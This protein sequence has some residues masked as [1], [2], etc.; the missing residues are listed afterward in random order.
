[1][2]NR[3][4]IVESGVEAAQTLARFFEEREDEVWHA[5]KLDE[6]ASLLDLVQ[7]NLM[8][9]DI[10]FPGDA[11][12]DFLGQT[13]HK[14]PNLNIIIT[15]KQID[16][17]RE[18]L[19]RQRGVNVFVRQPFTQR[20]LDQ[21][22]K[23]LDKEKS[24]GQF[25]M[26]RTRTLPPVRL[27]MR[28]KIILPFLILTF[29]FATLAFFINMQI[30]RDVRQ[31]YEDDRMTLLGTQGGNWQ[32]ENEVQMLTTLREA[33]STQGMS[34]ALVQ[35]DA[36]KMAAILEPVA[37][38]NH[39]DAIEVL[40][41]NGG[42]IFSVRRSGEAYVSKSGN[43][44]YFS[45]Q[46]AI[47]M[48]LKGIA[49][50][51]GDKYSLISEAPW[52]NMFYLCGPIYDDTGQPLGVILVGRSIDSI[53]MN[54]HHDLSLDVTLYDLNGH[55]LFTTLPHNLI[56]D[57]SA[58]QI[59]QILSNQN[60]L[61]FIRQL[62]LGQE[63]ADEILIPW[64]VRGSENI[65][66][67]GLTLNASPLYKV[68]PWLWVETSVLVILAMLTVWLVGN[69]L[70]RLFNKS[71]LRLMNATEEVNR[72]NLVTKVNVN[73]NDELSVLTHAFNSMLL[74]F[75]QNMLYRDLMG[76]APTDTNRK[77]MEQTFEGEGFNLRGQ[78]LDV[79]IL[80]SDV[81]DFTSLADKMDPEKAIEL[82]ND[83]FERLAAIVVSYNGVINKLEGDAMIVIFGALPVNLPPD[84]SAQAACQAATAM[85]LTIRDFNQKNAR[86][87]L[88]PLIT[89]I[90]IHTGPVILGGL[91]IRDQLH[92]APIGE[93]VRTAHHLVQLTSQIS[94][95]SDIFISQDTWQLLDKSQK[96]YYLK[97][98]GQ[99]A[100][101]QDGSYMAVYRLIPSQG[102]NE[103]MP[104]SG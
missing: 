4:L 70:G 46:H 98:L 74:G 42:D 40:D 72:G 31:L 50:H 44:T 102:E 1:M 59:S 54:M 18:V 78:K 81:N 15:T 49:D 71:I 99:Y 93:T 13:H 14:F 45:H 94:K 95:K 73:G 104:A 92:Y 52:G 6:A 90:S 25:K 12:L 62:K 53:S 21:A 58:G 36:K 38:N 5:W 32:A 88:P 68:N 82:L 66:L 100:V 7:P 2:L 43:D 64:K 57:L 56:L 79:T 67:M 84:Q 3:V 91:T 47:E 27:P 33:A 85:L 19:A 39:Q 75:Q 103:E 22:L 97:D 9:L 34:T 87:G 35:H 37:A 16:L 17:Q 48:A 80:I 60:P 55:N 65:G 69:R 11:W 29:L 101:K 23:Q 10:H 28:F 26:T 76:Y 61:A 8:L 77:K 30:S 89:G 20:W 86:E 41:L 51:V 63:N 83:Y 96:D 24:P